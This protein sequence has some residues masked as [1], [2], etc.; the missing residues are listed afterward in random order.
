MT[1][2]TTTGMRFITTDAGNIGQKR[3]QVARACD[4]CRK[5][6]RRCGHVVG[7]V[8]R[9]SFP[10]GGSAVDSNV[11]NASSPKANV[12][13]SS[14]IRSDRVQISENEGHM[15]QSNHDR[16]RFIGDLN[17]EGEF[18]SATSPDTA[19]RSSSFN[20]NIGTWFAEKLK[21][22]EAALDLP[23]PRGIFYGSASLTHKMLIR[24]MEEEC[25]STLPPGAQL[26]K[27]QSFYVERIHP[28]LPIINLPALQ[29]K[30][31]N[32]PSGVLLSQGICL[33]ASMNR[34]CKQWL[35][36]ID[37][38]SALE[39]REFA[40]RIFASMRCSVEI[41]LVSDRLDLLQ[42]MACMGLFAEGPD[43]ADVSSQY[44]ARSVHTVH[45]LGLHLTGGHNGQTDEHAIKL[46][47]C[48]WTIDRLNAAFHGRPVLL[49]ERDV[50]RDLGDC[51]SRQSPEFRLLLRTV[52]LL[53]QVIG[54]YR[55]TKSPSTAIFESGFPLF[56]DILT[57][58]GALGIP[59]ASLGKH[60]TEPSQR[61][62]TKFL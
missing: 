3:K 23:Q 11:F 41:G 40:R 4:S 26:G 27:L 10:P 13:S 6:K 25:M 17:P 24:V 55:P 60:I 8:S 38:G 49:H 44:C 48:V 21:D 37:R 50:G 52:S 56:E 34:H 2:S 1:G 57:E 5:R 46:L 30:S 33:L 53:D 47:C 29:E 58:V 14:P 54:L 19:R 45:T 59:T 32:D 36:P 61:P 51:F 9:A 35:L 31:P 22:N 20:E 43:G 7:S 16:R 12:A 39:P 15:R 28:I 62:L 18:L 42:A